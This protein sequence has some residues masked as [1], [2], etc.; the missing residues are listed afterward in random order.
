MA[1]RC[2]VGKFVILILL[3]IVIGGCDSSTNTKRGGGASMGEMAAALDA[4][5]AAEQKEQQRL[6]AERK[7]EEARQAAAAAALPPEER[8]RKEAKRDPIGQGGYL[9]AIAGARRHVLNQV[10]DWA[11]T[12][13][14]Q[15]FQATEG[16]LP[17]DH[18]EFMNKIVIPL[19]INLGFKEEGHEFLYDPTPTEDHPWGIVYV[20]EKVEEPAQDATPVQ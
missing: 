7:A 12:Q 11:W 18:D 20:V 2:Q 1:K 4:R 13:A 9:T 16:R 14:V 10:E 15:H 17:K 5:Q 19:E 6:E 8:R 3:G